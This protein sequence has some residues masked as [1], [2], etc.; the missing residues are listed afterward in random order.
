MSRGIPAGKK[1]RRLSQRLPAGLGE[2]EQGM[3]IPGRL[4]GGHP[5]E[6]DDRG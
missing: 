2:L 3:Q 6:Q 5:G 1:F 4:Q